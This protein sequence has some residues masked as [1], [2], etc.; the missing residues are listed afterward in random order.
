MRKFTH[1][2]ISEDK[3]SIGKLITRAGDRFKSK[4]YRVCDKMTNEP[5]VNYADISLIETVTIHCSEFQYYEL[6]GIVKIIY[7][8]VEL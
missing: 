7:N 6:E 1:A 2:Y 5:S 8:L 4:Y 3:K